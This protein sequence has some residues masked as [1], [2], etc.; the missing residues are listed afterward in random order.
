MAISNFPVSLQP[1]IQLGFLQHGFQ[2]ALRSKLAYRQVADQEIFQTNVG[3]SITKTRIGLL[4][5]ATTPINVTAVS[6]LAGT[7]LK[8]D[9]GLTPKAQ[10]LEQ[11]TIVLNAYGDTLDLNIK[12]QRVGIADRFVQNAISQ[13]EQAAR[14]MDELARNALFGGDS[15]NRGGY[16]TGNTFVRTTLGAAGAQV[17][18]DDVRGFLFVPVNGVPTGVS[19]SAPLPVTINGN[20]YLVTAV[21]VDGT[22]AS[23]TA[24]GTAIQGISGVLTLSSNVTTTDATAGNPVI[25]TIAPKIIRPNGRTTAS[26][27]IATDALTMSNIL[28]AVARLRSN[29]V[30]TINGLYNAYVDPS[31]GRQLF[32]DPD[33]KQLFQ[34]QAF[35]AAFSSGQVEQPFLGVRFMQTTEAPVYAHPSI[36]GLY[37]HN[38]IVCGQGALVEGNFPIGQDE[39]IADPVG[40]ATMNDGV[41]YVVRPPIDRLGEVVTQSWNWDGGFCTPTDIT[42]NATTI[43]TATSA[44]LKRACIIQHTAAM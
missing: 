25:A 26:A 5:S 39:G 15:S 41:R 37:V 23:V 29:A 44:A 7:A 17:A 9:S 19:S 16:L 32:A 34:G 14:T 31:S 6:P 33:F 36:A 1:A 18:V 24:A 13:G 8:L 2:Q 43:P 10:A 27:L 20:S 11:Y 40:D 22:N 28:D 21:A 38:P 12:A 30:P 35:E 3:E 4:P 42:T